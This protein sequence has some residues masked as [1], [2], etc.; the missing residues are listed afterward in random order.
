M[1]LKY[2]LEILKKLYIKNKMI[3]VTGGA[4]FIGSCFIKKLNDKNINDI[5]VVDRLGNGDK[6]KNLVGKRIYNYF[7]KD[8]FLSLVKRGELKHK[9][10]TAIVHLG[11]CTSTI[12]KNSDYLMD[13]NYSYS[14]ALAE[15][16]LHN[17]IKFIYASSA[18][19]YGKAEN[20][21]LDDDYDLYPLNAYG[22]S[23]HIFD[24]WV[25]SN[26]YDKVFTGLKFFNVFGPNEYHKKNMASMVFKA[27]NQIRETGKVRLFKSSHPDYK[28]GEQMRDFVYAKDVAD[29]IW[30]FLVKDNKSGIYNLGTGNPYSWNE[31]MQCVFQAMGVPTDIEY[32]DI[33]D[34]LK[35]QYQYYTQANIDKLKKSGCAVK[36]HTLEESVTDYVKNYLLKSWQNY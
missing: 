3:I 32:I 34:E 8:E 4:G 26:G 19:T 30:N 22:F 1:L 11:A 20:G 17:K 14:V 23:K 33:P 12:E 35:N 9:Q 27:F 13:N 15:Y 36:F 6:W 24:L 5:L 21:Y 25:I 28:D 10:I 7:H 31:L 18:A 29:V 2:L 16:A